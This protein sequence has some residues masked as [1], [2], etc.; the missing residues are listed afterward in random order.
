VAD[1]ASQTLITATCGLGLLPE[2]AA[3][4]SFRL[5]H[6]LAAHVAQ[7]AEQTM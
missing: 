4:D 7:V 5:A 2:P 3:A 1:L 6:A